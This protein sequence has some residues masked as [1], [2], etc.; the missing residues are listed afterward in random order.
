MIPFS[1]RQSDT[2]PPAGPTSRAATAELIR[3][4]VGICA[5]ALVLRIGL[6]IGLPSIYHPDELYQSVEQAHRAVFGYGIVP[7]EFRVGTRSWLLPGVVAV[8]LH[9]MAPFAPSPAVFMA[10]IH[11]VFA[12]L[13]LTPVVVACLWGYRDHGRAGAL[14]AGAVAAAWFELVHFGPRTLTEVV[15]AHLLVVAIFL[16]ETDRPRR[17]IVVGALAGLVFVLRF[18]LAP[19]LLVFAVFTCG[20]AIRRKWLPFGCGSALVLAGSGVI[21]GLT[22]G[23]PFEWMWLNF[24]INILDN[25][26]ATYGIAPLSYYFVVMLFNW[27]PAIPAMIVTM[28]AAVARHSRLLVLALVIVISHMAIGHKEYRFIYPAI[29]LLVILAGLGTAELVAML[30]RRSVFLRRGLAFAAVAWWAGI[31]V[32]L[33]VQPVNREQWL[34]GHEHVRAFRH[35]HGRDDLCGVGIAIP[36]WDTGGYAHLH[37][38]VPIYRHDPAEGGLNY[39]YLLVRDDFPVPAGFS[40]A[41][42]FGR[43]CLH[44]RPG[45]CVPD[46]E[47]V[48]QYLVRVDD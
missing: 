18:H 11:A 38:P 25:R 42:C 47:E 7:W 12:V 40:T 3:L 31:S 23:V 4:C 6:A 19:A 13:S 37:R 2:R 8:L 16:A 44:R 5:I 10:A 14:I 46:G 28:G 29:V 33:A 30:G 20:A 26:S 48:N 21:D 34:G 39:N 9:G 27:G 1:D 41:E 43:L 24:R 15:A 36:W 22:W 45:A 17:L 32:F 35:L